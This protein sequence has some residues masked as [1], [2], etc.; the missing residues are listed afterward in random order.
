MYVGTRRSVN[1][2]S[3]NK[4][5]IFSTLIMEEINDNNLKNANKDNLTKEL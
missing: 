4:N 3:Y 2:N 5:F 1:K